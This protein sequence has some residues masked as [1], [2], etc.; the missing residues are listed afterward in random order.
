[1][2]LGQNCNIFWKITKSITSTSGLEETGCQ[3][4]KPKSEM[5]PMLATK[6]ICQLLDVFKVTD[7]L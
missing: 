4:T 7:L 3:P 5:C 2:L 6:L 1:V